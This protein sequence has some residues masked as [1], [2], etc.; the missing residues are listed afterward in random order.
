[1][2]EYV[3]GFA[4]KHGTHILEKNTVADRLVSYS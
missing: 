1:M 4:A 2:G 3:G